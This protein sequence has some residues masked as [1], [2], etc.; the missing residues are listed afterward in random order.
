M[1]GSEG[2][3]VR[4][5]PTMA[6]VAARAGVSRALVSTV[7]RNVPGA[8]ADTRARVLQAAEDL[9]YRVDNRARLLRRTRTRLLGVMFRLHDAFHAD[10]VQALYAQAEDAGYELVLSAVLPDEPERPETSAIDTLL[11]NRCEALLLIGPQLSDADLE[12]LSHRCPTVVMARPTSATACDVVRTD[13]GAVVEVALEHLRGLGHRA[14]AHVD[15]GDARGSA[16]RRRAYEE[17][18][19]AHGLGEHVRVVPGGLTET[20]GMAAARELV[21]PDTLPS[22]VIA[23]DDAV[24]VGVMV[25]LRRLGVEVP[26]QVSVV[27]F[28]DV[29]MA[30]LPHVD[31]TTVGQDVHQTA[32]GAVACAV[33]R[34]DE[35]SPAGHQ[36]LVRPYLAVRGTTAAPRAK[37]SSVRLPG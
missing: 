29:Q 8:S 11:D 2:S 13:D 35:G 20:A 3:S 37:P 25:E 4:R 33:A 12:A 21:E 22:A 24:A 16:E 32:L 17:Q 7:F 36:R 5:P 34:L 1:T 31:L 9:G 18:M 6:D 14:I 19:R 28:D 15:G 27:G 10:L 23:F 30:A 26:G